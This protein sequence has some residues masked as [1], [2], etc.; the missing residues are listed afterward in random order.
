MKSVL[1]LA[2]LSAFAGSA[3]ANDV[4][5]SRRMDLSKRQE[6]NGDWNVSTYT[7]SQHDGRVHQLTTYHPYFNAKSMV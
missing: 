6:N 7:I 2:A 5:V 4:L 3:V 1:S